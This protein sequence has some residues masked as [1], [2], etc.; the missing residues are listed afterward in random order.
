MKTN[1]SYKKFNVEISINLKN[2]RIGYVLKHHLVGHTADVA[3]TQGFD[4]FPIQIRIWK[5][6]A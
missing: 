2:W 5:K 3:P 4:L 1:F 6:D